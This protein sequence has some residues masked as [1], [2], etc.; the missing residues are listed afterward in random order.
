MDDIMAT[1]DLLVKALNKDIIPTSLERVAYMSKYLKTFTNISNKLNK[2]FKEAEDIRPYE[3]VGKIVDDFNIK[4]LYTGDEGRSKIERLRDFYVLLKELDDKSKS[5]KDSLQDI[6]KITALS[7]GELE[8]LIINRTKK[9]RIPI[10]TVHQAKG[11]EY[12]TVFVS[13]VQENTFPS[14]MEIKTQNL[15]EEKRTFYVAITRAKKRLYI[16][17]NTEGGC[18]RQGEESR[19]ISLIPKDYIKVL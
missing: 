9:P 5:S 12:D 18:Y 7:N 17:Y 3:I 13:G 11:L 4:T 10:I 1:K 2:L 16:T 19:F 8:S 6:I 15:E 14:Y